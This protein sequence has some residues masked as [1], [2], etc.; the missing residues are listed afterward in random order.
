M[1]IEEALLVLGLD[2]IPVSQEE[3]TGVYRDLAKTKHP[4]AGGSE[5]EFKELQ[6]ATELV[7]AALDLVLNSAE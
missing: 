1:K 3:I 7:R 2:K 6:E 4:D 5:S